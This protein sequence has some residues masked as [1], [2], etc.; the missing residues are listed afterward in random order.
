[1]EKLIIG[2]LTIII[3]VSCG[4]RNIK[5]VN[6]ENNE[7]VIEEV[8]ENVC[9]G[10]QIVA[11]EGSY[12]AGNKESVGED[13]ITYGYLVEVFFINT[14]ECC[15]EEVSVVMEGDYDMSGMTYNGTYECKGC[16]I[17]VTIAAD[18]EKGVIEMK[19]TL[20]WDYDK[21]KYNSYN[22]GE[23]ILKVPEL[24]DSV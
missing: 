23:F 21:I 12:W 17:I 19:R 7:T 1:M 10:I 14:T 5:N 8:N 20:Y 18:K 11:L 16:E 9:D 4:G 3:L 2:L 24:K 22:Y 6:E 13:G 15:I